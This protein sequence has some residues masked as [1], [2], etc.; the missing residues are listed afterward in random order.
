MMGKQALEGDYAAK[1]VAMDDDSLVDECSR[2]I[3]AVAVLSRQRL[4]LETLSEAKADA[5]GVE[6][7]A[8]GKAYLYEQ[9]YNQARYGRRTAPPAPSELTAP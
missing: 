7:K 5:C 6:M 4:R 3:E 2:A 8:R 1:L 9:A